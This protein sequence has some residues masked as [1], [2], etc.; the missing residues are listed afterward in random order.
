M[1]KFDTQGTAAQYGNSANFFKFTS[2][3]KLGILPFSALTTCIPANGP[4]VSPGAIG[5]T[6]ALNA[7]AGVLHP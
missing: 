4:L 7:G 6:P 5:T 3:A 2:V 1:H